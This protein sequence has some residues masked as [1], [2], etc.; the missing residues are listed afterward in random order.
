M[1]SF[2]NLLLEAYVSI[3]QGFM[4]E[5]CIINPFLIK[6]F[7]FFFSFYLKTAQYVLLKTF[8]F[9]YLIIKIFGLILAGMYIFLIFPFHL[10]ANL[11]LFFL[12]F[13]SSSSSFYL[14]NFPVLFSNFL[15]V[16][17]IEMLSEKYLLNPSL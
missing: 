11:F 6:F 7:L 17:L 10:L 12:L 2:L 8:Y 14:L 1:S 15:F 13:A 5:N 16:F 9:Y 3:L 4:V